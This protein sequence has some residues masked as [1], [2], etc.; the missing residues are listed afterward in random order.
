MVAV[1]EA[2]KRNNKQ[3]SELQQLRNNGN[4][5]AVVYGYKI[6]N[7]PIYVNEAEFTKTIREAG[8]NG[9]I[10]LNL[11]GQK[12]NVILNEYQ[13]DSLKKNIVHIDFLAV[14][15][16]AE[17]EANVRIEI[18]GESAGVKD[19]GVLQQPVHELSVTAKPNDIPDAIRVD[20]ANLQVGETITVADIRGNYPFSIN[21]E[22]EE[23]IASILPPRQEEEIS[24]GEQQE[25]GMPENLEGRETTETE[26]E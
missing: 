13:E 2:K 12:Q 19:G 5:P 7:T 14:D 6:E 24:T 26:G 25:S 22:D 9:V 20:V 11:E 8:R 17:I 3:H 21:H 1:L 15:L 4:I 23:T 10:S 16:S 18:V